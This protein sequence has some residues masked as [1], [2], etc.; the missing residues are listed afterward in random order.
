[1]SEPMAILGFLILVALLVSRI[2][3]EGREQNLQN[4]SAGNQ[5]KTYSGSPLSHHTRQ[6]DR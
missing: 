2:R 5:S 3:R 4:Q 1:M 6:P